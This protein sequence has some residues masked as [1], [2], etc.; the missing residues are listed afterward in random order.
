MNNT[1]N[2]SGIEWKYLYIIKVIYC[3]PSANIILKGEKN[4]SFYSKIRTKPGCP[5]SSLQF[6]IALEVLWRTIRQE[7][8]IK[9][10]PIQNEKVKVPL[11]ADD[12][13]DST[14]MSETINKCSKFAGNNINVKNPL[15][16]SILTM[17]PQ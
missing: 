4:K 16:S 1:L 2:K 11:F 3:K 6:N 10:I 13:K 12:H 17:K 14:K 5:L 9:S 7:K 15:L 8:D